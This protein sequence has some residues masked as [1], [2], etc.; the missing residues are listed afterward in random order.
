MNSGFVM[1]VSE[2]RALLLIFKQ[3]FTPDGL[4][5]GLPLNAAVP[6]RTQSEVGEKASD[7]EEATD[8]SCIM[9]SCSFSGEFYRIHMFS[10][11]ITSA[12]GIT[13]LN[14]TTNY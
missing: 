3:V 10:S 7:N 13:P 11:F 8:V 9:F 5:L 2:T 1:W 4:R 12:I 6:Q 14:Q